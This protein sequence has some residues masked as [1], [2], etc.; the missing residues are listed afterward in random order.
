MS[1]EPTAGSSDDYHLRFQVAAPTFS[2]EQDRQHAEAMEQLKRLLAEGR[3]WE[4]ATRGIK[5]ADESFKQLV[6][7][8]FLKILLA[9]RHFQGGE[10]LKAIAKEIGAPLELLVSMK[11]EMLREVSDSAQEAYRISRQ[12]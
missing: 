12:S 9:E 10:R 11:E 2:A 1:D 5:I 8:D 3:S 6:L 7:A 4:A